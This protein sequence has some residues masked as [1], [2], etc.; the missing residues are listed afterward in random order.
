MTDSAGSVPCSAV[1]PVNVARLP[2][3]V[4]EVPLEADGSGSNVCVEEHQAQ[5][6]GT[7]RANRGQA[8]HKQ[9]ANDSLAG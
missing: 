2:L 7:Q 3:S 4:A 1:V 6:E 5:A 9:S 8:R